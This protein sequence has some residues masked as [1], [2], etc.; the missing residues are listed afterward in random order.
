MIKSNAIQILDEN[1]KETGLTVL[2]YFNQEKENDPSFFNWLFVDSE[3]IND[4]GQGMNKEQQ[5]AFY[6]FLLRS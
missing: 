3:N 5:D 2:E 4:Y 1:R 6:S